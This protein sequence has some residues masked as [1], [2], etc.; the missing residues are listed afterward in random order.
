MLPS[1]AQDEVMHSYC[2]AP[3]YRFAEQYMFISLKM[4]QG[5]NQLCALVWVAVSVHSARPKRFQSMV[6]VPRWNN[7]AQGEYVMN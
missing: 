7:L 4:I 6:A 2:V 3:F 5:G 1:G